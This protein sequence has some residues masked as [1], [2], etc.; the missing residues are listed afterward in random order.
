MSRTFKR[1]TIHAPEDQA[2]HEHNA[3]T[4]NATRFQQ[5]RGCCRFQV[6]A[7]KGVVWHSVPDHCF[8]TRA[9]TEEQ[10]CCRCPAMRVAAPEVHV[11]RAMERTPRPRLSGY[12]LEEV[13]GK[14]ITL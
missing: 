3:E 9:G 4:A 13:N 2:R 11:K 14:E 7:N 12:A 1:H 6:R 10:E 8:H 5:L